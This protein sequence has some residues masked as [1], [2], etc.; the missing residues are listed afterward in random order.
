MGLL[1]R[2]FFYQRKAE[3]QG[4][5]TLAWIAITWSNDIRMKKAEL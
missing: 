4:G 1:Q 3:R 2:E 5:A